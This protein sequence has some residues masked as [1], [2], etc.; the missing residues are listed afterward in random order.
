MKRGPSHRDGPRLLYGE[1]GFLSAKIMPVAAVTADGLQ[2]GDDGLDPVEASRIGERIVP[3]NGADL[4]QGAVADRFHQRL[5]V[6][7]QFGKA[8]LDSLLC[9]CVDQDLFV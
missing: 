1:R 4:L 3:K 6:Q 9:Q 2:C 5:C 8:H 7:L